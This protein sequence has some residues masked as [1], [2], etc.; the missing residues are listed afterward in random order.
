MDV[1]DIR[2][3]GN[4]SPLACDVCIIGS[5]PAGLTIASELSNSSLS[6]LVL[7]SGGRSPDAQADSLNQIENI[8]HNRIL[9]QARMRNRV[10]GGSSYTWS[11]RVAAFDEIDFEKRP[12]VPL[13]GWP[14]SRNEFARYLPRT[15]KYFG[16]AFPDNIDRE[17][18]FEVLGPDAG[19]FDHDLIED[20]IWAYSRAKENRSRYIT[21]DFMRFGPQ[22]I[23]QDLSGV[24]CLINATVV[25]INTT[26][27]G[28]KVIDLTVRS[29]DGS[30]RIVTPQITVLCGGGIENAR[31]LLS[32]NRI[33]RPGVG[34]LND[35][36]GRH[37]MDHPHG[38]VG[39]VEPDDLQRVQH[40]FGSR[41][42]KIHG[43]PAIVMQGATLSPR[44]Q[45]EHGLLNCAV[46]YNGTVAEDD[47]YGTISRIM[48]HRNVSKKDLSILAKNTYFVLAGSARLL[49][50]GRTP[51]RRLSSHDLHAI[52]EQVPNPDSRVTLGD[53]L[54]FNGVPI[55]RIDWRVH[56]L[57]KQSVVMLAKY[58]ASECA[59]LGLPVPRLSDE[60]LDS[61]EVLSFFDMAHPMGTTRMSSDS[62]NG[63]VD[64]NCAVHGIDNLYIA[65]SSI[66]P[67]SGHA[68]PTQTLVALAIRLADHIKQK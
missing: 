20:Y 16:V 54:D 68:N 23:A 6:I 40:I 33:F 17:L 7:E 45:R 53:A 35:Q 55:S 26:H 37:L 39:Q 32:S 27:N 34:N 19:K 1:I 44:A 21:A 46:W 14:I 67:T 51:A 61:N 11:G 42:L 49:F 64:S 2:S 5:G 18:V 52:V 63:V 66:F 36:V 60:L 47:P 22:A 62:K 24:H 43:R 59:R 3:L 25:H 31:L 30:T 28:C 9:D 15:Q 29:P 50:K 38:I 58:F 48:R 65:G 13:S 4:S 57:E 56:P 41:R 10:F 8:G 12:W